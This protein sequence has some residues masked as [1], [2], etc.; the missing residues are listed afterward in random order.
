MDKGLDSEI[1]E[2]GK[3]LSVGQ[4]Q[5]L[6][7]ARAL[8]RNVK[9]LLLDEA[10]ASLD[11]QTDDLVRQC[12]FETFKN[13]TLLIIAH[14]ISSVLHSNKILLMDNGRVQKLVS[15]CYNVCFNFYLTLGFGIRR[16]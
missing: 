8:L 15:I 11:E 3:N 6:C 2:G 13:C 12:L 4:R 5:L 9:I 7:L 14:R 10:T 1:H 16:N